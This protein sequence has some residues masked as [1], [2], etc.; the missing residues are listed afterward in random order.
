MGTEIL[1]SKERREEEGRK[2]KEQVI[3]EQD[4]GQRAGGVL[5]I[6]EEPK[7]IRSEH[8]G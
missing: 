7:P 1:S 8:V 3:V 5:D 6:S 4:A 2:K